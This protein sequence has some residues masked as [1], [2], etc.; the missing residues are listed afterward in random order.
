MAGTLRRF[1]MGLKWWSTRL[2]VDGARKQQRDLS[3]DS[4]T[5]NGGMLDT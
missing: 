4:P 5:T 1:S 2:L 3:H